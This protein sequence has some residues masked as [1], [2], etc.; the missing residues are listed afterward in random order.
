M[1]TFNPTRPATWTGEWFNRWALSLRRRYE[2]EVQLS[3]HRDGDRVIL[4]AIKV[5][6]DSQGQGL[7]QMVLTELIT[8]A[9]LHE[10]TLVLSPT[11][12]WG[13]NYKRLTR[14]YEQ[15]GFVDNSGDAYKPDISQAMYRLP[16]PAGASESEW[17]EFRLVKLTRDVEFAVPNE[18][19]QPWLTTEA[20]DLLRL[21]LRY[22]LALRVD[23]T[24]RAKRGAVRV[25]AATSGGQ[26]CAAVNIGV[27][28]GQI[29]RGNVRLPG[30]DMPRVEFARGAHW[31]TQL[32][33]RTPVNLLRKGRP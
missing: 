2:P 23:W 9:D 24:H 11:S 14:W 26:M 21:L 17:G 3:L 29:V 27:K 1:T 6:R 12:E 15:L 22:G 5:Q 32:T 25:F 28:S 30:N 18:V 31:R 33:G 16:K 8:V 19:R 13:A 4:F 20:Y 7:G 10:L